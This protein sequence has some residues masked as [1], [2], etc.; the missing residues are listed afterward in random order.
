MGSE[1]LDKGYEPLTVEARWY[2]YWEEKQ[3]FAACE[4]NGKRSYSIVIPPPNV[5]GVLHMGHALNVT[6]Q[7][8]LCRY[9]RLRGYNVLWMPEPIMRALQHRMWWKKR[10]RRKA[11]TAIDSAGKNSSR[12]YGNGAGSMEVRLSISSSGLVLHATGT[13]TFHHG[14]RSVQS[15][16]KGFCGS[17]Q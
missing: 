17:V 7:D 8:I 16:T 15:G 2:N 5:T 9:K 14:R 11:W 6:L 13:G 4:E 1:A 12:R 3:L 10:W